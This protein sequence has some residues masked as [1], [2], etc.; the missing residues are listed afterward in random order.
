ML[1]RSDDGGARIWD[2]RT[3][4]LLVEMMGPDAV[5]G[6]SFSPDGRWVLTGGGSAVR[7]W[8]ARTG[9]QAASFSGE[10]GGAFYGLMADRDRSVVSFSG[11]G[12]AIDRCD[13]CGTPQELFDLATAR[14][15]RSFTPLERMTYLGSRGAPSA[16]RPKPA[17]LTDAG[18]RPVPDGAL[19]PGSYTAV[20]FAPRFSFTLGEGWF[21]QTFVDH[22]Q[23]PEVQLGQ[24]VQLQQAGN[25][26]NGLSFLFMDPGRVI[27]GGK[28]W[29]ER[30]S[31]EPFPDDLPSWFTHH[32]NFDVLRRGPMS[33]GGI[34]G[35]SVDTL[36][37]SIPK[38]NPWPN[39]GG[40]ILTITLSTSNMTGPSGTASRWVEGS[41]R[42]I[43][44][45]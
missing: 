19:A 21:A 11:D 15:T 44:G 14:A 31:I 1:S 37:T 18:A 28:L 45:S 20:G 26:S 29:D 24:L 9:E 22:A 32:P 40:C 23:P 8:D 39:C 34:A 2:P 5:D 33:V 6:I 13:A 36:G 7:V 3:G 17:G 16:V 38:G 42:S 41:A 12:I 10:G 4:E 30:R 27:D 25:L 43:A 35:S